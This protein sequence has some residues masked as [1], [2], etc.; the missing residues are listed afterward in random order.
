MKHVFLPLLLCCLSLTAA[1][2]VESSLRLRLNS[3]LLK[4]MLNMNDQF[5]LELLH[6]VSFDDLTLGDATIKE[7]TVTVT[8]REGEK[9]EFD[10]ALQFSEDG[11]GLS[12]DNL[13]FKGK[14]K[15]NKGVSEDEE[16]E[17]E[18][19]IHNLLMR[20]E[21][22]DSPE[23]PGGITGKQF[24]I[25]SFEINTEPSKIVLKPGATGSSLFDEN[26]EEIRGWVVS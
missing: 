22:E 5:L 4:E 3:N 21:V 10:A 23:N 16:F 20:F 26:D 13:Y 25:T 24:N 12:T 1:E 15:V 18:G 8:P 11:L 17:L 2:P 14:G 9:A 6:E 7:V 19:P